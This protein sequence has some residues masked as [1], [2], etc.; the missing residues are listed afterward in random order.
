MESRRWL[1]H[2]VA[3]NFPTV[4]AANVTVYPQSHELFISGRNVRCTRSQLRVL[5][6]LLSNFCTTVR[7][8]RLMRIKGR[9]I[10][11]REQNSLK[12]TIFSLRTMLRTNKAQVE[13]RNV[14]GTGYQAQPTVG[15]ANSLF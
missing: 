14:Y 4:T 12:V 6:A 9:T 5:A 13:I 15:A 3:A 10:N 2:A 1:E 7:Y 11:V 8:E